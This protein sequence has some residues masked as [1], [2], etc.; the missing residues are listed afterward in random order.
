MGLTKLG[1]VLERDSSR[2]TVCAPSKYHLGDWKFPKCFF[3]SPSNIQTVLP[4][5]GLGSTKEKWLEFSNH[6]I[7][8]SFGKKKMFLSERAEPQSDIYSRQEDKNS[9]VKLVT[10]IFNRKIAHFRAIVHSIYRYYICFLESFIFA[11]LQMN[12]KIIIRTS[13]CFSI[14]FLL[15]E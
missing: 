11:F 5:H 3:S 13:G 10:N 1:I 12:E 6:W 9:V 14:L 2:E 7:M 15:W 8:P 4:G